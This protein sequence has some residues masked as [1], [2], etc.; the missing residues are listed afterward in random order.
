MAHIAAAGASVQIDEILSGS[1]VR[2]VVMRA[3][4]DV[5]PFQRLEKVERLALEDLAVTV[6]L[7][8]G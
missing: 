2:P 3:D 7:Y 6:S 8:T 1:G 4:E 5:N